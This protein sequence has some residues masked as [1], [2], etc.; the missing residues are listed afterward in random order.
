[1][2]YFKSGD[3]LIAKHIELSIAL[4]KND[5]GLDKSQINKEDFERMKKSELRPEKFN[6]LL[7]LYYKNNKETWE[8]DGK[9]FRSME[10]FE[11][12]SSNECTNYPKGKVP[13]HWIESDSYG[14]I[15]YCHLVYYQGTLF[16]LSWGT[17]KD[18]RSRLIDAVTFEPMKW[19]RAKNCSP[20]MNLT[21]K[22][23][24]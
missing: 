23:I 9:K 19:V 20:I 24:R 7:N 18:S 12:S 1:M 21:D 15:G 6:E 2:E 14:V 10:N 3:L 4:I 8:K 16:Y 22:V 13:L 11:I 17:D 5:I